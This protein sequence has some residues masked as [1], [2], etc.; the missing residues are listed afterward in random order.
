MNAIPCPVCS[1]EMAVPTFE[2]VFLGVKMSP[3][4]ECLARILWKRQGAMVAYETII[5][6]MWQLS[7]EG[8]PLWANGTVAIWVHQLRKALPDGLSIE[9]VR[10]RG[11]KMVVPQ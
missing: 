6:Q 3:R 7:P 5:D 10:S 11:I 1:H 9:T 4:V 8:P 2:A